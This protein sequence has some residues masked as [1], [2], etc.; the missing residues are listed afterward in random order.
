MLSDVLVPMLDLSGTPDPIEDYL[1]AL[2]LLEGVA[3]YADVVIPGHGSV[4]GTGQVSARIEQDRAYVHA[5]SDG[6]LP[7][8]RGL[9]HR[10]CSIGCPGCMKGNYSTSPEE[11]D[12]RAMPS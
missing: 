4:G 12:G 11:A 2:R 9:A 8:T 3:D 7:V 1:A 5:L 6:G 10:P